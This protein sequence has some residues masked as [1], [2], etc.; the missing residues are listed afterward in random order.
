MTL[1][2]PPDALFQALVDVQRRRR[3]QQRLG[4][5]RLALLVVGGVLL[6]LGL[7][8]AFYPSAFPPL[9][10]PLALLVAVVAA[11]TVLCTVSLAQQEFTVL[12]AAWLVD[13]HAQLSGLLPTALTLP[14]AFSASEI[15]GLSGVQLWEVALQDRL[16]SQAQETVRSLSPLQIL[17]APPV[18]VWAGA[19][20][21]LGLA[22]VCWLVPPLAPRLPVIALPPA[23]VVEDAPTA[24][25]SPAT[26]PMTAADGPG[27]P[28][29]TRSAAVAQPTGGSGLAVP[30]APLSPVPE[31]SAVSARPSAAPETD[32]GDRA[33]VR[34][35]KTS[36]W[37]DGW[38][39]G[40]PAAQ[41]QT[42][43][44][45]RGS[46]ASIRDTPFGSQE[47]GDFENRLA[48][49]GAGV[50]G[51]PYNPPLP[52]GSRPMQQEA[53]P[54]S[55]GRRASSGGRGIESEGTDKCVEGCLTSK[56]MNGG[57]PHPPS[58]RPATPPDG[59][60][61]GTGTSDSGSGVAG[62]SSGV[63]LGAG[64]LRPMGSRSRIELSAGAGVDADRFQVLAAPSDAQS[65]G[66][67]STTPPVPSVLPG[68]GAVWASA[69]EAPG[70]SG[71]IP[72]AAR[73]T[74]RAYFDRRN[75]E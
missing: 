22:A 12:D 18:R 28:A 75:R 34:P 7:W 73:A 3:R 32:P 31:G 14:P 67:Q 53:A 46:N 68:S 26:M 60:T 38:H 44:T 42:A 52:P 25:P 72:E 66:L 27:E 8:R 13:S 59:A 70:A 61:A 15:T 21:S 63:G 2:Q 4:T 49:H 24:G 64:T 50:T 54:G 10:F 74:I 47:P 36:G 9:S 33:A 45:A 43:G 62:E 1:F 71:S 57:A 5:L 11:L 39:M 56:D 16:R 20:S 55:S 65:N 41:A 23:A 6:L 51:L 30:R 48:P 17:P 37:G 19:A 58:P 69:L 29:V 40:A 35:G